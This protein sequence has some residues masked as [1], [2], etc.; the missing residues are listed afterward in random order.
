MQNAEDRRAEWA[1]AGFD[2]PHNL[3]F[4]VSYELP[5]GQGKR[6]LSKPGIVQYIAGGWSISAITTYQS[7]LPLRVTQNNVLLLFNSAQRPNRVLGVDARNDVSYGSFDP[8]V[9]RLFNPSAFAQAG[10][11]V[12]GNASPRLADARDFGVV[13]EDV[14]LRKNFA[15]GERFKA[16]LAAQSFNI[17]NRNQWGS[18]SDN[19]SASDFGKVTLAGPGR[20]VQLNL[21]LRF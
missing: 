8:A 12:F 2:T 20:F 5:F 11:T 13:N 6:L 10:S 4:S 16:E 1:V 3:R 19:V 9:E 18:A 15:I 14:A 17:F 21:K 7:G